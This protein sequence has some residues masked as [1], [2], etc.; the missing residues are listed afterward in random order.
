MLQCQAM[1][2]I[3][4]TFN[5][6][7]L[8]S[9]NEQKLQTQTKQVNQIFQYCTHE[10][11]W[12]CTFDLLRNN[13]YW[14]TLY[15]SKQTLHSRSQHLNSFYLVCI[16]DMYKSGSVP[17]CFVSQLADGWLSSSSHQSYLDSW[18][19]MDGWIHL[20]SSVLV[21][22]T[23]AL[24]WL[25]V[26]IGSMANLGHLWIHHNMS[27]WHVEGCVTYWYHELP[28]DSPPQQH[29]WKRT[30]GLLEKWMVFFITPIV[31]TCSKSYML[32]I[33]VTNLT[34]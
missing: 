21:V 29:A 24:A 32:Y 7:L 17:S 31:N 14:I 27:F 33:H 28:W 25:I 3:W 5:L 15:C 23:P 1:T 9:Q 26:L 30:H 4:H 19:V 20:G 10:K 11:F 13:S 2:K 8:F 6:W 16:R 18:V 22:L 34:Y 12:F